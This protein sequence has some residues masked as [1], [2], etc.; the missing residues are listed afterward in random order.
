MLLIQL[1]FGSKEKPVVKVHF[2]C[3]TRGTSFVKH[4][5]FQAVT[6][7]TSLPHLFRGTVPLSPWYWLCSGHAA[8]PCASDRRTSVECTVFHVL[9]AAT[10]AYGVSRKET[11]GGRR[12]LFTCFYGL[13][14]DRRLGTPLLLPLV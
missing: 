5:L 3:S 1:A 11:A 13:W 12:A 8:C 6:A 2:S 14:E 7:L 9:F 4:A 10:L